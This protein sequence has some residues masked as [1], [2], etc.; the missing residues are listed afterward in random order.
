VKLLLGAIAAL[1]LVLAG[2]GSSKQ[3]PA[4]RAIAYTKFLRGDKQEV[5]IARPDGSHKRRLAAGRLPA[6]SPDGRWVAFE[7]ACDPTRGCGD[8]FVVPSS[9]GKPRRLQDG[10]ETGNVE[11]GRI[12][13]VEV[14]P[15]AGGSG[16]VI[17][18]FAGEASWNL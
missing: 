14:V 10:V 3:P 15:F 7:G 11:L 8:L 18:R 9:G 2:C 17:A 12:Q 16:N 4:L 13:H 1:A 5:W 6:L